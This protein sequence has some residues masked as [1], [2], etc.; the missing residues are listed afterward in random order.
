MFLFYDAFMYDASMYD[1][2]LR[3]LYACGARNA[4]G[5]GEG[6]G[7]GTGKGAGNHAREGGLAFFR[8]GA[9]PD[10]ICDVV[11]APLDPICGRIRLGRY[12]LA[13]FSGVGDI[14]YESTAT[15][16]KSADCSRTFFPDRRLQFQKSR[17]VAV[18]SSR[19][20]GYNFQKREL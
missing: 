19:S 13:R 17:I 20:D 15:I 1:A 18:P 9:R 8:I 3:R 7:K 6:T 4:I 10:L 11:A 16:I 2:S 12:A 5:T 14:R